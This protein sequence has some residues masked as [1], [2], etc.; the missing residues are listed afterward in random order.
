MLEGEASVKLAKKML[1]L[2]VLYGRAEMPKAA[3]PEKKSSKTA[4]AE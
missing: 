1:D 4:K 3:D 2:S